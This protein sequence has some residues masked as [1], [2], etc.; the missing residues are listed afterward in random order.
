MTKLSEHFS[1]EELTHSDTANAMGINNMPPVGS[2][3][4]ERLKTLALF[5][6]KVRHVCGDRPMTI[7]DAYR[8][9]Q[10]N[11][12]VGGV[13]NSAHPE[14]FA[15]DFT[16]EGLTPYQTAV[17]LDKAATTGRIEFDQLI[18]EQMPNPTWVHIGRR[19]HS[20]DN[21]P[22]MQRLTKL[23]DGSYTTGIIKP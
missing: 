12:A 2:P 17:M 21:K 13:P 11:A 19:L 9:P 10:V 18:L 23:A 15:A 22:R 7:N 20:E 8:N 5:L 3:I 6:E 4:R 1:L 16:V 14:G